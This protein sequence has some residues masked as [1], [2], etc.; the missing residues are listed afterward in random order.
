MLQAS[1]RCIMHLAPEHKNMSG[2]AFDTEYFFFTSS[3]DSLLNLL[4]QQQ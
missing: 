3:I 1:F 2:I 4:L